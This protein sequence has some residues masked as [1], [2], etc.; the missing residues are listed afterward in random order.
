MI[1]PQIIIVFIALYFAFLF[2]VSHITSRK[3]DNASFFI[4][5]RRSPWYIVSI[6]MIGASIS[7]VTFISVP[8]WVVD[9]NFSYMAMVFG[10]VF[11]YAFIAEVLLPMFYRLE[12]TS[13]YTYLDVRFGPAS[14]K[15]GSAFFLLSRTIG[16]AF[17]LYLT[18]KVL[19][20]VVFDA[21]HVP[22]WVTV[23]GF[24]ALIWFYTRKG[25]IKTVIWTDT[26]QAIIML[27]TV[28]TTFVMISK[29]MDFSFGEAVKAI[30]GNEMSRMFFFDD[31]R[32]KRYFIKQF[33]SGMV[34]TVTMTGLD[35]GMMQKNLSCRSIKDA[36]K[37]IYLYGSMFVPINLL[38]LSLGVMLVMYAS[39]IGFAIPA[40]RDDLF[41]LIVTQGGLGTFVS[42]LFITGLTAAAYSSSDSCLTA[43]TTSFTFDILGAGNKDAGTL[44]RTR[45]WSHIMFALILIGVIMIFRQLNNPSIISSI[46]TVAGYT[47]GP[48]LGLYTFGFFTHRKVIDRAVPYIAVVSPVITFLLNLMAKKYLGGYQ[49]AY[50]FLLINGI[51]TFMGLLLFSRRASK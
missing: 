35:Q 29:A 44:S 30:R 37:N 43:L 4:G 12:L 19:Q 1:S 26:F 14:Y 50:E 23:T 20:I 24:V 15:T 8:G 48:L 9:S 45:Q 13:I 18:T 36:K 33:I 41:P 17:R 27:T 32:D 49:V 28:V 31:I 16:S 39:K 5:N 38:F 3:A 51:I 46:Y 47:Y 40:S 10:F 11:G 2:L 21:L 7:G 25:G 22:F 42:L 6:G 34:I